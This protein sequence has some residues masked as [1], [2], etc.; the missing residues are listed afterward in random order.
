MYAL[1]EKTKKFI[2]THG[3]GG[4]GVHDFE[5]SSQLAKKVRKKGA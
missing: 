2:T 3:G 5:S 1:S 4:G